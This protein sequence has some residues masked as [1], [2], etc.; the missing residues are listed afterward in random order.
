MFGGNIGKQKIKIA[1]N[2][3]QVRWLQLPVL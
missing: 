1:K 2:Q 3:I